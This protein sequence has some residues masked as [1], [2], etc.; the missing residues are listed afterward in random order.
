MI[1]TIRGHSSG[2]ATALL[3]LATLVIGLSRSTAQDGP[4]KTVQ[5]AGRSPTSEECG[6]CH[7]TI[8][9]EYAMG[10]GSD[11]KYKEAASKA[12]PERIL[13]VPANVSTAGTGHSLAALDPY[14][15]HALDQ[16]KSDG[17]C[18]TCHFPR[19]FAIPEIDQVSMGKP[20]PRSPEEEFGG[21]RCISCHLTPEGAIR[22]PHKVQASHETVQDERIRT[23]VMCAYCHSLGSYT[24]GTQTQTFLEWREDFYKAGLGKLHCQDCHMPRTLRKTAEGFDVP[25]RPV[26]RHL[27]TGGHSSQRV[28]NAATAV[29]VQPVAGESRLEFHV[30]N[31]GA[32]HSIPS[33]SNRR[34]LYLV[35]EIEDQQERIVASR[36]WLFAPWYGNRPDDRAFVEEDH[37]RPDSVAAAQADLQGPHEPILRAGENRVLP[38]SPSLKPG[39]YTARVRLIYDL[40][41]YNDWTISQDQTETVTA[42]LAFQVKGP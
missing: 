8:Y 19:T 18:R 5:L 14:P 13:D 6:T 37:N 3:I 16:D 1:Q 10:F 17:S 36:E 22:T 31:V 4:P 27:W 23:S 24:P 11:V 26:A 42:S 15:V 29:I 9:R 35:A 40:N 38:W 12:A 7:M 21:V 28:M 2:F 41:R 39:S 30:V 34:A 32:G 33:G 20:D 25:I